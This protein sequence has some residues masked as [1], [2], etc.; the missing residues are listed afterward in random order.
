LTIGGVPG[1]F[2][3][4]VINRNG[5][6]GTGS[7]PTIND[8][9]KALQGYHDPSSLTPADL[10]RYDVAPL[11]AGGTPQGNGAIDAA[12]VVLILRRTIGIGSW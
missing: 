4:T 12:D 3:A 6:S 2:S 7:V 9:L 1:T 10:I 11:N 5:N 8:A